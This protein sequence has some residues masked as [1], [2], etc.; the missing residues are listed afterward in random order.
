MGVEISFMET[1]LVV[2]GLDAKKNEYNEVQVPNALVKHQWYYL[3][4]LKDRTMIL[5]TK[6]L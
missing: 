1:T 3:H 5:R 4:S 2:K 6:F